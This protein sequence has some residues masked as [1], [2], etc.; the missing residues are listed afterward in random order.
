MSLC[1]VL[2]SWSTSLRFQPLVCGCAHAARQN[3]DRSQTKVSHAASHAQALLPASA[4]SL[5]ES[6]TP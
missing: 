2:Y 5:Y 6:Q 3:V 4:Q 1:T